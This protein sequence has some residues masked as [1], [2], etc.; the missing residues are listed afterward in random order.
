MVTGGIPLFNNCNIKYSSEFV[1]LL[2]DVTE[3]ISSLSLFLRLDFT[4][5]ETMKDP[6][7][8]HIIIIVN[9]T[10]VRSLLRVFKF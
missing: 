1:P 5:E 2:S 6:T 9:S 10:I 4:T 3:L 8:T 7:I